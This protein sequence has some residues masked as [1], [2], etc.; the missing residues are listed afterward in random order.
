MA[1]LLIDNS[2][3]R[4]K[5]A[6]GDAG[7]LLAWRA[8]IPTAD[9]CAETLAAALGEIR[10][11]AVA[12]ASVV[13]EK[14]A[15]LAE[16]FSGQ[17]FHQITSCSPLGLSFGV[18]Q[19]ETMGADRL[20]N[21]VA[22]KSKYGIPSIA[23]DFGTAVTFSVLSPEGNFIGGAIAPGMAAMTGYLADRTA[24]LPL[25]DLS[26]PASPIGTTTAEAILSGA[27]IGH[28]GMVREILRKII[29]ACGG[30]PKVVATGG[31]AEFG[32]K[33]I[34]E[35]S[36]IDPDLTLEGVRLVAALVFVSAG[37]NRW[38]IEPQM[39]ADGRE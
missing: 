5:L 20:A 19:P 34:D 38:K 8:V 37:A 15:W 7:G 32:T 27:V 22:L 39:D 11:D 25:V 18:P 9:L 6:L 31:G 36:T 24:Q 26:E 30:Q 33:G 13:P 16:F 21:V 12:C 10:F 17:P 3:S 2:N 35:I 28:R 23:I 1:W 29:S 4:T 14:A